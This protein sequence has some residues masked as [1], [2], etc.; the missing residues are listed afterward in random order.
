MKACKGYLMSAVVIILISVLWGCRLSPKEPKEIVID[1]KT[2][3]SGFYGTMYPYEFELSEEGSEVDGK[4][5]RKVI[6]EQFELMHVDAGP[7]SEGTIYCE[8]GMYSEAKAYY[9]DNENYNYYLK[10]GVKKTGDK[11][12]V[13]TV[14]IDDIDKD[15]FV[16]LI[17]FVQSN[18]YDPFGK[19]KKTKT[20]DVAMPEDMS[21]RLVF[22][23]VSKDGMFTTGTGDYFHIVDGKLMLVYQYDY[24]K[25]VNPKMIAVEVP[26][27]ISDY[28]TDYVKERVE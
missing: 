7:Y 24:D 19:N 8:K 9:D 4:L 13:I 23:R 27:D 22:Y 17:E 12:D 11:T 6:S 1:E 18:S 20:K 28:I 3:V 2:Y 10:K 26:K 21:G 15:I 14:E 16:R 5:Y 25:G